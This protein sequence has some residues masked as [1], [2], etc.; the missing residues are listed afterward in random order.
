MKNN[1]SFKLKFLKFFIRFE[2]CPPTP[3]TF[4]QKWKLGV[5]DTVI[6]SIL[7]LYSPTSQ[8]KKPDFLLF[9]EI[10]YK[11]I[12]RILNFIIIYNLD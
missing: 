7:L 3:L 8:Y 2:S 1:F 10:G 5:H 12:L 4:R 6:Y 9:W 11:R